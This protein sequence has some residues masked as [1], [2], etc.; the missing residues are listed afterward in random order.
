MSTTRLSHLQVH[1]IVTYLDQEARSTINIDTYISL[2]L[3]KSK[4]VT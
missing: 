4:E 2:V 3:A 1:G